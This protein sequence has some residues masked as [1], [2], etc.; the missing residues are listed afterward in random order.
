SPAMACPFV[1]PRG[2]LR[3]LPPGLATSSRTGGSANLM[4]F[5]AT[6]YA[7]AHGQP[8]FRPHLGH[9]TGAGYVPNN[10]SAVSRLLCPRSPAEGC[11][12]DITTST[13]T[14][15][16]KPFWLLDGQSLLPRHV[17]QPGGGYLQE[18]PYS[19]LHIQNVS[20][21]HVGLLQW[22][23]KAPREY[24]TESCCTSPAQPDVLQ[25]M[26]ISAKEQSGFTRNTLRSNSIL[27]ALPSHPV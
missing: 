13:T 26:T 9:H 1:C 4:D 24:G 3:S 17:H 23:P 20:P 11:Y 6:S 12:Q 18:S 15:H 21:Q 25:K 7:V 22:P 27:P 19:C 10:R 14:E 8:C 16:F 5:Y 2:K